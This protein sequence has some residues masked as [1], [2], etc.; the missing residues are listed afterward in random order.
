MP[1]SSSGAIPRHVSPVAVLASRAAF[2]AMSSAAASWPA[3]QVR[4][5][6]ISSAAASLGW[7]S[8]PA[9]ARMASAERHA[10]PVS[11]V[12]LDPADMDR[13][14]MR[15]ISASSRASRPGSGSPSRSSARARASAGWPPHNRTDD[16]SERSLISTGLGAGSGPARADCA[17]SPASA[18]RPATARAST[19][20]TIRAN[21]SW[22]AGSDSR[23]ARRARS[24][25]VCGAAARKDRAARSSWARAAGAVGRPALARCSAA[26]VTGPPWSSSSWPICRCSAWRAGRARSRREPATPAP[27]RI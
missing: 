17:H 19:A 2:R 9:R 3:C 10:S 5:A 8:W 25:A 11:S 21:R 14:S 22:P 1:P 6:W 24:A 23:S 7:L 27:G 26:S 15:V 4:M 16:R 20:V 12:G 18:S 13:A